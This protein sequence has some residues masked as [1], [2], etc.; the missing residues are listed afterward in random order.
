MQN[1]FLNFVYNSNLMLEIKYI[2][3]KNCIDGHSA[4]DYMYKD[5][6]WVDT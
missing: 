3:R 4:C 6:V 2:Y 5:Y 1:D